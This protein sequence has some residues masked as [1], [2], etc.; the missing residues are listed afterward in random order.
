VDD[1]QFWTALGQAIR[2]ARKEQHLSQEELSLRTGVHRNYIGGIERGERH[3]SALTI[4]RLA[5]AL[6]LRAS[7]LLAAAE[8]LAGT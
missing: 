6:S 7:D 4:A 5:Q 3:P 2:Q 8:R 1:Q